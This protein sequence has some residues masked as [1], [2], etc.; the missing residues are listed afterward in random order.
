MRFLRN[1]AV[2]ALCLVA[3]TASAD[4]RP[5][6]TD[7]DLGLANFAPV[8]SYGPLADVY[9]AREVDLSVFLAP[10]APSSSMAPPRPAPVPKQTTTFPGALPTVTATSYLEDPTACFT[11]EPPCHEVL[12]ETDCWYPAE[13]EAGLVGGVS[14]LRLKPSIRG[15][16]YALT[17][18]GTALTVGRS[19]LQHLDLD[20]DSGLRA[21]LGYRTRAGWTAG[22]RYLT[23]DF[24]GTDSVERPPGIGQL[25]A[26]RSHPD[27]NE[28]G[29]IAQADGSLDVQVFDLEASKC[30]IRGPFANVSL[31][32]AVRWTELSLNNTF[33]YDGRDFVNGVIRE[34]L[35]VDGAGLQ[36]GAQCDWKWALG[37]AL[38]GR[39]SAGLT[40]ATFQSARLETN[41]NDAFVLVDA[42]DEFD[43]VLPSI[44]MSA[45][46]RWT[47]GPISIGGSYELMNWFDAY[48][49]SMFIDDIHEAS[50]GP[51]SKDILLD[52][53]SL[54]L[55][56]SR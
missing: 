45:G 29:D 42:L 10:V 31:F 24:I 51:F 26:T 15:L 5:I 8:S 17:E 30:V 21:F 34:N 13:C 36:F 19:E 6:L 49:R 33:R 11:S 56:Y 22:V 35:A 7:E 2:A 50:F 3:A 48:D 16:D 18:D 20:S 27:G 41:I 44:E 55:S 39:A 38:T 47:R 53:F 52:G 12:C 46:V 28:E 25:F 14:Y 40:R 43:Q 32:G 9:D 1:V 4:E 23:T 37:F 54:T